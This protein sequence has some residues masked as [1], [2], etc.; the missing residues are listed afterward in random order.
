MT[1]VSYTDV[2][3]YCPPLDPSGTGKGRVRE[4]GK[5]VERWSCEVEVSIKESPEF[6]KNLKFKKTTTNNRVGPGTWS[7]TPFPGKDTFTSIP[8]PDR[9]LSR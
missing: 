5:E 9:T 3:L 8:G 1:F 7:W 4:W 2:D 6:R